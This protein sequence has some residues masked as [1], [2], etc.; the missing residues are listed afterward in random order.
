MLQKSRTQGEQ[1]W[2]TEGSRAS[3]R[4][5]DFQ[6]ELTEPIKKLHEPLGEQADRLET[7]DRVRNRLLFAAHLDVE[8]VSFTMNFHRG[9]V[10]AMNFIR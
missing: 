6:M 10:V 9:F 1:T 2:L 5:M 3:D 8:S 7:D 4:L